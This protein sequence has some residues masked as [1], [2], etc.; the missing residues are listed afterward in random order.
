M[1]HPTDPWF[2]HAGPGADDAE[3]L[4]ICFPFA[5]GGAAFYRPWIEAAR[6]KGL[7]LLAVELPGR[8]R[9]QGEPLLRQAGAMAEA[10]GPALRRRLDRPF[11][12]FGHSLGALLAFETARHLRRRYALLPD[13]LIVSG[14][15]APDEA[16]DPASHRHA[17]ALPALAEELAGLNGTAPEVLAHPELLPVI[18]P[19][20]QA[21]FAMT[22]LHRHRDEAPLDCPLLALAGSDDPEVAPG[23]ITRWRRHAAGSFRQV[24]LPGDHFFLRDHRDRIL[25]EWCAALTPDRAA[26]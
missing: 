17:L 16:R 15:H 9:R 4:V 2:P 19:M 14:R 11:L 23:E 22:E 26:A 13:A 12:L 1:I 21:D 7:A 5:G 18:A 3:A 24:T 10:L 8:G 20:L 6:A 25:D